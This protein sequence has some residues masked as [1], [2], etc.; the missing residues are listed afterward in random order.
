MLR[1][2]NKVCKRENNKYCHYKSSLPRDKFTF[3]YIGL[4]GV[5]WR[6]VITNRGVKKSLY[7]FIFET[8]LAARA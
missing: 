4:S 1:W 7:C 5:E 8:R 6:T 3:M 2:V